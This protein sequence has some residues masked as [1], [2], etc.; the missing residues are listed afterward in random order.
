M[1]KEGGRFQA[2]DVLPGKIYLPRPRGKKKH[3]CA[4]CFECQ[5]CTDTRCAVCRPECGG[6]RHGARSPQEKGAQ[7][8]NK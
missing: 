4:E 6:K 2:L 7:A 1:G 8:T 5:W 3:P